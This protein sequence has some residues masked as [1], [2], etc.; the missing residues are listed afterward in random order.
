MKR[1]LVFIINIALFLVSCHSKKN[2]PAP[3]IFTA[4][5]QPKTEPLVLPEP[6]PLHWDTLA[7]GTIR[8]AVFHLDFSKMKKYPFDTT[9]FK[10]LPEKPYTTEF[11]L[12]SLPSKPFDLNK[13]PAQPLNMKTEP[14]SP[15]MQTVTV[16]K[17]ERVSISTLDLKEWKIFSSNNVI[18]SLIR[19]SARLIWI[20]TN[21]G[22]YRFDG[23]QLT[24]VLS[25]ISALTMAFDPS[26]KLWAVAQETGD[27]NFKL[28]CLD[29]KRK[30]ISYQ[31]VKFQIGGVFKISIDPNGNLWLPQPAGSPSIVIDTRNLTYRQI[32]IVPVSDSS[33]YFCSAFD[34]KGR[35]W[36]GTD[37]GI[38][39]IDPGSKR[40][41][42]ME[43]KNRHSKSDSVT[44]I[45]IGRDGRIWAASPSLGVKAIDIDNGTIT[46]F[47]LNPEQKIFSFNLLF[48][49]KGG[50]WIG[51]FGALYI[52][53][54]ESE[55][56]RSIQYTEGLNNFGVVSLLEISP[57][58]ILV[59][60]NNFAYG[61]INSISLF[62][63]TIYP[64]RNSNIAFFS[65]DTKGR[66]WIDNRNTLMV[67]DSARQNYYVITKKEGLAGSRINNIIGEEGRI[68]I[69]TNSGYNIFDPENNE[70][71]RVTG[72]EGLIKNDIESIITDQQGNKWMGISPEGIVKYDSAHHLFLAFIPKLGWNKYI[73]ESFYPFPGNRIVVVPDMGQLSIIDPA[74]N[75]IQN[76]PDNERITVRNLKRITVDN[77]GRIWEGIISSDKAG[78]FII[79]PVKKTITH[80]TTENGLSA[81]SIYSMLEY[82]GKLIAATAEKIDMIT[83]PNPPGNRN[84]QVEILANSESLIKSNRVHRRDATSSRGNY[85]W[86]GAGMAIIPGIKADTS[87]GVDFVTGI[88][89]M[90]KPSSFSVSTNFIVNS[91]AT[92]A[93]ENLSMNAAGYTVRGS[94]LWDSLTD[95]FYLPVNLSLPYDQNT[96]QFSYTEMNA[97]RADDVQFAYILDG[98]DNHWTFTNDTH[99]GSY[100]NLNPGKYIFKV[101]SRWKNGKWNKPAEFSFTIR[102]PWYATWWA[103]LL[104]IIVAISLLRFY[105]QYRSRKLMKENKLLEE[106][107]TQRT[108]ELNKSFE[109]LKSTQKQLIQSEKMASLGE[110]M[111]GIAHEIQNPLNFVNNFSD[112]NT[113]LIGEADQEIDKGNVAEV[114]DIL[115]DI[116]A[117]EEKINHHGKRADA[118]VKEMLQHSRTSTG[119]KEPTDINALCD[120]YLRL[121]Y[122]GMRAKDKSF[123]CTLETHFDSSLPKVNVVPQDIGRVILNLI[124]NAFYACAERGRS[125]AAE[126]K[127]LEGFQKLQG[128]A[129]YLPTVTVSTKN[130]GGK[131]EISVRD[132][133]NGIPEKIKDKIFQPFF[134]TKPTGQGTGLGLSLSYDI[135]RAHEGEIK[136]ESKENEGTEFIVM[137]PTT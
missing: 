58:N 117:N 79:D 123:N 52:L 21:N 12:K 59:A 125:T 94:V 101:A 66:L 47:N 95:P 109:D 135:V 110:L 112:I 72:K 122:H 41:Y 69:T 93:N 51:T 62:G 15:E 30:L 121:A 32:E 78:I 75:T 118:I 36:L 53:K 39:I 115:N 80:L 104:Y 22:I 129:P 37:N 35:T 70:L 26:G 97:G 46:H 102:P 83:P 33:I 13:I 2:I 119:Q 64:F 25:N 76:I 73:V 43:D 131:V 92:G 106:K 31:V 124:N 56:F 34:E 7:R 19:D 38:D 20:G 86:G 1:I 74:G 126:R 100:L 113:E 108:E 42:Y 114:K 60:N 5:P 16:P 88:R 61:T 68:V 57:G 54:P 45:T 40:I 137:L 85:L 11:N 24:R 28:I 132:N 50:L 111:A 67:V 8:P 90:G 6:E 103:Y 14:L 127:N 63:R 120:E 29:L 99:S 98:T 82:K 65:E 55:T 18:S 107:V 84:W 136:V 44:A 87:K 130:L 96:I 10:P 77:H 89:I 116:R 23:M 3:E 48:D 17:P 128:L 105:V 133:G 91:T 9:G 27:K 71:I 81:A 134:T 4:Y 49:E